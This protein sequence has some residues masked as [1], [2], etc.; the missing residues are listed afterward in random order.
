MA[1]QE[2]TTKI[3]ELKRKVAALTNKNTAPKNSPESVETMLQDVVEPSTTYAT[4][5]DL[6]A[7]FMANAITVEFYQE[8]EALLK[9]QKEK[10]EKEKEEKE[11]AQKEAELAAEVMKMN[12]EVKKPSK[13]TEVLDKTQP[14]HTV[15]QYSETPNLSIEL[16]VTKKLKDYESA[17][18]KIGVKT[19]GDGNTLKE[20]IAEV[21]QTLQDQHPGFV[22][23][24]E[25]YSNG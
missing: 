15:I 9:A 12:K 24:T 16:S 18:L 11:K 25:T 6:R 1:N 5:E 10:E 23:L 7:A 19:V 3:E 2:D 8:Q 4:L 20:A 21:I 17:Q 22:E 13:M 14:T